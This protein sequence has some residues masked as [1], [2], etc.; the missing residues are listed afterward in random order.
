MQKVI[1]TALAGMASLLLMSGAARAG[2]SDSTLRGDYAFTV[3]GVSL[4]A[5]GTTTTGLI[6]GVGVATFDG[7]GSLT[8]QDFIVRNG[9]QA[10]GGP[11]N[12]SGFHTGE[13]G[14]Y[15]VNDDC[16][17]TTDIILGPGN[18][19]SNAL[20]ISADGRKLHAVVVSAL[21][22]GSPALLQ[23]HADYEKIETR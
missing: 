14:T 21:V 9:T 12:A 20:V 6:D 23:V 2:C 3:H 7:D 4:S 10:P 19:R 13:T 11:P 5:D 17:G 16:T 15:S 8:Q 18:E 22:G 1:S